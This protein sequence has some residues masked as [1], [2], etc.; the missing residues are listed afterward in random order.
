MIIFLQCNIVSHAPN[1]EHERPRL[2]MY[3]I[4]LQAG[5]DILRAQGSQG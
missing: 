1:L 5:Q 4:L 2:H 3:I